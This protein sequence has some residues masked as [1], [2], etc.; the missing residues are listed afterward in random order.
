MGRRKVCDSRNRFQVPPKH[1]EIVH[2]F[3]TVGSQ[4]SPPP[5]D[6]APHLR[7]ETTCQGLTSFLFHS[8]LKE[9]DPKLSPS[10]PSGGPPG[11]PLPCQRT[12]G[13]GLLESPS[14]LSRGVVRFSRGSCV[15]QVAP[16][17]GRASHNHPRPP[18]WQDGRVTRRPRPVRT[19]RAA[20]RR[21]RSAPLPRSPSRWS[22]RPPRPE[23]PSAS[24]GRVG[25]SRERCPRANGRAR[26]PP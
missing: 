16:R 14:A 3:S 10:Q 11:R 15:S 4:V 26:I 12:D 18:F 1:S 24:P 23:G 8:F 2:S 5:R 19:S 25:G 20:R 22:P 13:G 21:R 9:M 17:T 6:F 7:P